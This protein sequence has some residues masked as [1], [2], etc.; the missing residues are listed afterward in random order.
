MAYKHQNTE[1][2][3]SCSRI[4]IMSYSITSPMTR[5]SYL[6]P[7]S[8]NSNFE[9]T[10]Q[11]EIQRDVGLRARSSSVKLKRELIRQPMYVKLNI[12]A[13]SCNQFCSGKVILLHIL[14]VRLQPQASSM[15]CACAILSFVASP[16]LPYYCTLSH[17]RHDFQEKKKKTLLNTKCVFWFSLQFRL[18]HFSF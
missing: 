3:P 8:S 9:Y 18:K 1:Q 15:Q 16:I 2:R 10:G 14:N 4:N 12:K 6:E 11:E 5:G 7:F 13:R 17:K